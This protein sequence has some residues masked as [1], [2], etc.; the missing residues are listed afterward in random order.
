[1]LG[2]RASPEVTRSTQEGTVLVSPWNKK[3]NRGHSD[4][5]PSVA[6]Y[7]EQAEIGTCNVHR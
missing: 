3:Q 1:M 4:I 6:V 7:A 2:T 5:F